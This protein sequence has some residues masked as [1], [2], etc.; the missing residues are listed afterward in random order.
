M[1][2]FMRAV[3]SLPLLPADKAPEAF[4]LLN[5]INPYEQLKPLLAYV[6]RAW[7]SNAMF[8]PESWSVFGRAV[9]T[10]ND[11][12]G[13]RRRLRGLFSWRAHVPFFFPNVWHHPQRIQD[14]GA[15]DEAGDGWAANPRAQ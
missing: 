13:W 9:R 11:A 3:T 10:M 2:H 7:F 8:T 14:G 15:A 12:E 6:R 5:A 4:D 1:R